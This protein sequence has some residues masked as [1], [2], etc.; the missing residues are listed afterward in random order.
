MSEI[1]RTRVFIGDGRL[2]VEDLNNEIVFEVASGTEPNA[3][4]YP[5]A[6]VRMNADDVYVVEDIEAMIAAVKKLD[7]VLTE[8]YGEKR[9]S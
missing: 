8:R 9:R 6:A 7:E 5:F 2:V 4:G 1:E 3:P